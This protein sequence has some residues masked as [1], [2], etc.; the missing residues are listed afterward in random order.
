MAKRKAKSICESVV[1]SWAACSITFAEDVVW[2]LEACGWH[3][4][5][6][7]DGN[8]LHAIEEALRAAQRQTE[9]PSLILV[10]THLG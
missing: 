6:I 2:R 7:D 8:N 9:C 3:T 10:H 1:A 4:Q 5:S